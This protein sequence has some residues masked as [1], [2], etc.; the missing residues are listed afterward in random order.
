MALL[1]AWVLV[2]LPRWLLLTAVVALYG[3]GYWSFT[4]MTT[5][6]M[7]GGAHRAPIPIQNPRLPR[8]KARG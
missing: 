6:H 1:G 3:I 4:D 2:R 5:L 7:L 8:S